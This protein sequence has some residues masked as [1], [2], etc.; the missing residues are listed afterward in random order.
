MHCVD[1]AECG[2]CTVYA[3]AITDREDYEVII[4]AAGA[5]GGMYCRAVDGPNLAPG[6]HV[7]D[8]VYTKGFFALYY[9]GRQFTSLSS[10][11]IT[12]SPLNILI[13][14]NVTPDI[15]QVEQTIGGPP[16][17]SDSSP[18]GLAAKFVKI[19]SYK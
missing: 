1:R 11:V 6:W 3:R 19:W 16:L 15:S 12:G 7:V 13:T 18:A 14:T 8:I 9:D 10:G 17:N 2:S 5:A 4:S